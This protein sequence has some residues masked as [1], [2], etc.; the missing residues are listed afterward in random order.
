MHTLPAAVPTA[1][2]F[3]YVSGCTR[4][5]GAA[6]PGSATSC[7]STDSQDAESPSTLTRQTRMTPSACA[8]TS[9]SAIASMAQTSLAA[10]FAA[11]LVQRILPTG[12]ALRHTTM[13]P[14]TA[15]YVISRDATTW[16][17][18]KRAFFWGG[19]GGQRE[20]IHTDAI[21]GLCVTRCS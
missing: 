3:R 12:R 8:A 17:R 18:R 14:D 19:K 7:C 2:L 4:A 11:M 15:V 9:R 5:V 21:I 1:T 20:G 16:L 6:P 13:P 10:A